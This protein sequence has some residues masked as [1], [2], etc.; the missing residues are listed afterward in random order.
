MSRRG[1]RRAHIQAA[2]S[3]SPACPLERPARDCRQRSAPARA[4]GRISVVRSTAE[5]LPPLLSE[6]PVLLP[7]MQSQAQS[8]W[9]IALQTSDQIDP[10]IL[11]AVILPDENLLRSHSG[12]REQ[13][14]TFHHLSFM[15]GDERRYSTASTLA[16]YPKKHRDVRLRSTD[17]TAL[18][19][20]LG[21]DREEL[22]SHCNVSEWKKVSA[23][24]KNLHSKETTLWREMTRRRSTRRANAW[25]RDLMSDIVNASVLRSLR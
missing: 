17:P 9:R 10:V 4:S 20:I 19:S 24:Q 23:L 25:N 8:P 12:V 13:T 1:F 15:G 11:G 5:R 18:Q 22:L 7:V 3:A 16:H 21:S 14:H 2:V 6:S